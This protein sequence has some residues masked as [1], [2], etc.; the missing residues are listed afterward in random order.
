ML[1]WQLNENTM[2]DTEKEHKLLEFEPPATSQKSPVC[3]Y[4]RQT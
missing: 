1:Q 3:K 4:T 2:I